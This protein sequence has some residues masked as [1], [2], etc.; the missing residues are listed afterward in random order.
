MTA[1]QQYVQFRRED[2]ERTV[3]KLI[4]LHN[5][6]IKDID[7]GKRF[8]RR[9]DDITASMRARVV[10]ELEQCKFFL[11]AMDSMREGDIQKAAALCSRIQ[12]RIL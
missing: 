11:L 2:V 4:D 10:F 7:E 1:T 12:E 6:T 5:Q 8:W 3:R 9:G